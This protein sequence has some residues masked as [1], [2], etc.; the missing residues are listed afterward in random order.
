V[1]S[2]LDKR[3]KGRVPYWHTVAT[4]ASSRAYHYGVIKG[5]RIQGYTGY[6]LVAVI[7]GKTSPICRKLNGKIYDLYKAESLYDDVA[8]AESEEI[9][10]ALFYIE[11]QFFNSFLE[12]LSLFYS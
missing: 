8:N 7:D 12:C 5:G 2:A 11:N 4:S 3:L 1:R 10:K 9:K 6:K